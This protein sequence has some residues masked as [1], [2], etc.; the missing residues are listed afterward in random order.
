MPAHSARAMTVMSRSVEEWDV[1]WRGKGLECGEAVVETETQILVE[2]KSVPIFVFWTAVVIPQLVAQSGIEVACDIEV[3]GVSPI[4][5]ILFLVVGVHQVV[6]S[7]IDEGI[8]FP[9][10]VALN[11]GTDGVQEMVVGLQTIG[12][13]VVLLYVAQI[14]HAVGCRKY[15]QGE[16]SFA[17][18]VGCVVGHTKTDGQCCRVEEVGRTGL[19]VGRIAIEQ[20][21]DELQVCRVGPVLC[22]TVTESGVESEVVLVEVYFAQCVVVDGVC[23]YVIFQRV[24]ERSLW[25]EVG[26]EVEIPDEVTKKTDVVVFSA[27]PVVA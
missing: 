15:R 21:R 18:F 9:I 25:V 8:E 27:S 2:F 6:A 14:L 10:E 17:C 20:L 7:P 5:V 23:A 19:G 4:A 1:M 3:D 13:R 12:R 24:V 26:I 22:R 11:G 16:C